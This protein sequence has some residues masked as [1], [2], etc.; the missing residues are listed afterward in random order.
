ERWVFKTP[1][2]KTYIVIVGASEFAAGNWDD[3]RTQ[4]AFD[5]ATDRELGRLVLPP[6]IGSA[7]HVFTRR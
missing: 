4:T 3:Y 7:V 5:M 2:V 1:S 6:E